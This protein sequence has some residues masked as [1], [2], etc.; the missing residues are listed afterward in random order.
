MFVKLEMDEYRKQEPKLNI[1]KNIHP[2]ASNLS[3]LELLVDGWRQSVRDFGILTLK[4]KT[5]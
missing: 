5:T 1:S 3:L 2:P 4:T